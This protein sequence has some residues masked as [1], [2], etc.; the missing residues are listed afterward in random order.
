MFRAGIGDGVYV[1]PKESN[2]GLA[3]NSD[4]EGS[5]AV[6]YNVEKKEHLIIYQVVRLI[7]MH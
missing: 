1:S 4:K 3:E 7:G 6:Y 2:H 5:M